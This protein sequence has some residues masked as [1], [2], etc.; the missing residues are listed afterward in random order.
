MTDRPTDELI[1]RMLGAIAAGADDRAA[2]LVEEARAEA[3]AEVKELV[4]SAMKAVLLRQAV[5]RL[6]RGTRSAPLPEEPAPPPPVTESRAATG[7]Y[8][9]GI[10]RASSPLP[11]GL[12]ALDGRSPLRLVT[13][14]DLQAVTSA[15][16]L[17]EFGP[18]ALDERLKDLQWVEA[19]VRGHDA[20]LKSLVSAAAVIPCRFCT[21]LAGEDEVRAV[22]SRA[23]DAIATTLETLDGKLEWGV[24]ILADTRAAP[25]AAADDEPDPGQ[26]AGRAY[27]MQKKRRGRQREE[28]VRAADEAAAACHRE[29]AA[30]ADAATTLPTRDRAGGAGWHLALNAAYLVQV[31]NTETFHAHVASLSRQHRPAGVRI[32]L[33]GPWPAYNFA[34]LDL[35]GGAA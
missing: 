12:R 16:S 30:L 6:E 23:H 21:I 22:L 26:P 5:G 15:V 10:T 2:A 9:Y 20:V 25:P 35:S 18:A 33:T 13:H 11:P 1:Q 28:V 31:A 32:D 4:K 24:K 8:V 27:L 19:N 17:D 29:L 34:A 14:D 3:E 7:C